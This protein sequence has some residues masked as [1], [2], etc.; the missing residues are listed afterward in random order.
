MKVWG[1]SILAALLLGLLAACGG[2]SGGGS[3]RLP[4][5]TVA[6]TP[7]AA[8]VPAGTPQ[9]FQ[10]T[11]TGSTNTSVSWE[12]NNVAGGNSTVG[13]I[14]ALGAY[15]AP[16]TIPSPAGVAITAISAANPADTGNA[17]ATIGPD[18][19]ISPNLPSI[20]TF[21]SVQFAATVTGTSNTAVTWQIAC[22]Q[23]G[24]ACGAISSTGLYVA[25]NSVPTKAQSGTSSSAS[26]TDTVTISAVSQA[27]TA[28][29][30]STVATVYPPNRLQQALPIE[31]GA[32]GSNAN[33]VCQVTSTEVE[34]HTGTLGSLVTR[35]GNQYILSNN[36]VLA[37]SD[38]ASIGDPI[39]QPGLGDNPAPNTCKSTGTNTV[40][41]LSQFVNL[42]ASSTATADAAIAQVVSGAVDP[43]GGIES[44]AATATAGTQPGTGA[45]AAGSGAAATL[46]EGVAKSGR[47]TGLTCDAV[48]GIDTTIQVEYSSGCSTTTFT[49]TYNDEV[50]VDSAGF[51]AEGDSGSLIVDAGTA[52]P[53]ALLFAGDAVSTVANPIADD[54]A[55]LVDS[56]SVQ[57]TF[58][59]GAEHAVAACS[60]PPASATT[61][62]QEPAVAADAI[63]T[64]IAV[65]NRHAG[66]LLAM[67]GVA[68][69]G[70][71]ASL[72]APGSATVVVFVRKGASHAAIPAE[73]DSVRTRVVEIGEGETPA[74]GGL[75]DAGPSA[76]LISRASRAVPAAL[77]PSTV[78]AAIH[79]KEHRAPV[80]MAD[81]AIRAVGVG[82]SADDP[83]QAA[84]VI[85]YLQGKA[86]SPTP[87]TIDGLRTRLRQT[88]GFHAGFSKPAQVN[89][90]VQ[91]RGCTA[92][93]MPTRANKALR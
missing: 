11:V 78:Q 44:L 84:L 43:T 67:A 87:N 50:M 32:S 70:V 88:T 74:P 76:Q 62:A 85:Y 15:T 46:N 33:D 28:F 54:L 81:P 65:R 31:L 66:T 49:E 21:A 57:P 71:A 83:D 13:T 37:R 91:S 79:I 34:C 53:V 4:M 27:N 35:E 63:D 56:N 24:T 82:V 36:H 51:S 25:P 40:A 73:L 14:T 39:I 17:T 68:A 19:M 8:M 3:T 92:S 29:V 64:A 2:G 72:D 10:A 48:T 18:V 5:V 16:V 77:P 12:V 55:A 61:K 59:G 80:L 6:V 9:T 38:G 58:V 30:G 22:A 60:L 7:T 26:V 47:S 52:E 42:Q 23:G 1:S 90:T 20:L 89:G 69:V 75:L 45:P 93:V 86:H 41:N